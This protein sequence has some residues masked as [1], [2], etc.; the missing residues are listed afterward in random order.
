[1]TDVDMWSTTKYQGDAFSGVASM[2]WRPQLGFSLSKWDDFQPGL[3][4]YSYFSLLF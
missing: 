2:L 4:L 3:N 1:M